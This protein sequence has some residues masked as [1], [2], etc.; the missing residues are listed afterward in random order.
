MQ[1]H[2][3]TFDISEGIPS[4][5]DNHINRKLSAMNGQFA[6]QSAYDAALARECGPASSDGGKGMKS[7][8]PRSR[9]PPS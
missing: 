2:P 3:F 5:Y 4:N 9:H 8:G 7:S 6:D 1:N